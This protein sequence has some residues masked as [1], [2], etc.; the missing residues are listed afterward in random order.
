MWAVVQR[1]VLTIF[2]GVVYSRPVFKEK[3]EPSGPAFYLIGFFKTSERGKNVTEK[4]FYIMGAF[5][6]L[7][8]IAATHAVAEDAAPG[9]SNSIGFSSPNQQAVDF[10]KAQQEL[11][12][13]K[14]LLG[15]VINSTTTTNCTVAGACQEG[16]TAT[17]VNGYSQTN[18]DGSGNNISVEIDAESEQS[19]TATPIVA[20]DIGS[21]DID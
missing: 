12:A 3:T 5:I 1:E 13:R 9:W 10:N 6:A 14:G 7:V 19:A 15:T 18:V 4:R 16:G 17:N 21:I 2:Y 8:G 11:L 20:D